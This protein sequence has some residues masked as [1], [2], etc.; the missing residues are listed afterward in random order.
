[1][2]SESQEVDA[3]LAAQ[4]LNR[5]A[6]YSSSTGQIVETN[7][8][9]SQPSSIHSNNRK[10]FLNNQTQ[11]RS[12]NQEK[13]LLQKQ[14]IIKMLFVV[15]L[16]YFICWTPLYTINTLSLFYP[17]AVYRGL[18]YYGISFFQLLAYISACCNPIT[19][20]F[21]NRK[22]RESFLA[23]AKCQRSVERTGSSISVTF[24]STI[25]ANSSKEVHKDPKKT[26]L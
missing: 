19:Y 18:G 26:I 25:S 9:C 24:R 21:M 13:S 10:L 12:T 20:C 15:V 17:Y 6:T 4:N 1:L 22:F 3:K 8:C 2:V 11:L 14:R 16:E 23:L 7:N 5:T